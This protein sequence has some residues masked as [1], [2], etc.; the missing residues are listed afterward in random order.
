MCMINQVSLPL[1]VIT[2]SF[3]LI[4]FSIQ[5]SGQ[6]LIPNFSFE[7]KKLCPDDRYFGKTVWPVTD[8]FNVNDGTPDYYHRCSD[9]KVSIP[10]NWAGE[11]QPVHGNAYMGLYLW[12]KSD[13][14]EYIGI[15]L[16][17]S[18]VA[19]ARY[20]FEGY[21]QIASFSHYVT[22]NIGIAITHLPRYGFLAQQMDFDPQIHIQKEDPL[23]GNVF[24]WEKITGSFI[25]KGGEK[26]LSVGN[27][28]KSENTSRTEILVNAQKEIELQNR[29]YAFIDH[30]RLW[31]EGTEVPADSSFKEPEPEKLVLSDI[32]FE[33]DKYQLKDTARIVLEPLINYLK[34]QPKDSYVLLISG[35]TDDLGSPEYNLRLSRNRAKAVA[36]HL[37]Q[38]GIPLNLLK[39]F[40]KGEILP[41]VPNDSEENRQKNRRVE[42]VIRTL[43]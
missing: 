31:K 27:F 41:L 40:G 18:L 11:A 19:D 3:V 35:Y 32:N 5:T 10:N 8:W 2:L 30:F 37:Y 20:F 12:G 36:S 16:K 26:Y 33:F 28:D 23:E 15:E 7:Q 39:V 1:K 4:G 25:A 13:Y 24:G 34:N 17:D 6:N 14:R 38:E 42:I 22:G 43:F 29:S 9:G 21:Y